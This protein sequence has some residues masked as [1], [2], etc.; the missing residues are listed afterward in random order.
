M[1]DGYIVFVAIY[2]GKFAHLYSME[3]CMH[4][5]LESWVHSAEPPLADAR[6]SERVSKRHA[7]NRL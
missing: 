3:G 4:W 2:V 5:H 7:S 1:S 6:T